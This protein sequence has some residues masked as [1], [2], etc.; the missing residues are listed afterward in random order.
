MLPERSENSMIAEISISRPTPM[1]RYAAQPPPPTTARSGLSRPD[2]SCQRSRCAWSACHQSTAM[3]P[4]PSSS[5]PIARVW[6][7]ATMTI[8]RTPTA[9]APTATSGP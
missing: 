3:P 1:R 5:G 8:S 6:P 2:L 7:V 9:I 4:A